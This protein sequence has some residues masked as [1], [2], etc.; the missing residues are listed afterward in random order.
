M[1]CLHHIAYMSQDQ[2]EKIFLHFS[3]YVPPS[4][5]QLYIYWHLTEETIESY[6]Y[7]KLKAVTLI[8]KLRSIIWN[9][10]MLN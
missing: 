5:W 8:C 1:A 4:I 9:H 10:F 3:P 7:F 2:S 6:L